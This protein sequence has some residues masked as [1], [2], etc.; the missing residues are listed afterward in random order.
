VRT[1]M[2][3]IGLLPIIILLISCTPDVVVNES[4]NRS[5]EIREISE[6]VYQDLKHGQSYLPLYSHIYNQE[7]NKPFYLTSTISIRNVSSDQ[8]LYL[9]QADYYNTEGLIVRKYLDHPIYVNPL[10][11]IEIVIAESDTQGGSG[12]KFIFDWAVE[13]KE[14]LPLIEAV[15]I[16]TYGQQGLSFSTRAVQVY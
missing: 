5:W 14:N 4:E 3:K 15:M 9:L 11:T 12:A 16:S 6:D 7:N 13:H 2:Q 10:E 1:A 8:R